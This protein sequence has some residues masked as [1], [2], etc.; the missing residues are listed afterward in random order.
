MAS[1]AYLAGLGAEERVVKVA[2]AS[3][4]RYFVSQ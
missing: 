2:M 4:S 1:G 3:E